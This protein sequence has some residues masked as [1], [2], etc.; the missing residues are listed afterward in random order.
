MG[1]VSFAVIGIMAD[2]TQSGPQ[3]PN[4]TVI[5][6]ITTGHF[7]LFGGPS[8]ETSTL[9]T[10]SIEARSEGDIAAATTA[11]QTLLEQRHNI[12]TNAGQADDFQILSQAQLLQVSNG[13]RQTLT[14]FLV[15][16]AAISLF[17]GGIGIMNIMLVAVTERTR[18]IGVRKALG[19]SARDIL[20]QF[21]I[22]ALP[23]E[24]LR[25]G[26]SASSLARSA[27]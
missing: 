1:G 26:S 9:R 10:I 25:R 20:M 18:E 16:I 19:A 12:N 13:V 7:R 15:C 23:A 6:P 27:P 5:V 17:V 3:D 11:A 8:L 2:R 14:L 24:S 22:E 4:D 21:V